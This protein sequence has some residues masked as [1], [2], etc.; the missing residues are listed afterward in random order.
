MSS[1]R[2]DEHRGHDL[3]QFTRNGLFLYHRY[4]V[5]EWLAKYYR[6]LEEINTNNQDPLH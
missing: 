3:G 1:N 2:V 4:Y 6:N 5:D